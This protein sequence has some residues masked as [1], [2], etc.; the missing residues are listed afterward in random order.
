MRAEQQ[1]GL[2]TREMPAFVSVG[3]LLL[4][5]KVGTEP[6]KLLCA[7]LKTCCRAVSVETNTGSCSTQEQTYV[8]E[9]RSP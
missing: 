1:W 7:K 8:I 3:T 6:F 2:T 5:R 9:V 4:A